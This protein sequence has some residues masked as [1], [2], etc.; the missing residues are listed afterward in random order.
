MIKLLCVIGTRPEAIKMIPIIYAL[1]KI[2]HFN[3]R[4]IAT[5]Q[6]RDMLDQV[7]SLFD[8]HVDIDLNIMKP[9]QTLNSIAGQMLIDLEKVLVA[10]SPDAVIAQG[11][12]TT[13]LAAAM[14]AF[15]RHIPFGHVEA[16]LR[17]HDR[18]HPFPEEMNRVI[19]SNLTEWHFAPSENAKQNLLKEGVAKDKI[20]L[21]G[22]T[23][24]DMVR[25]VTENQLTSS[26]ELDT[27]KRLILVTAHRRENFGAPIREIYKAIRYLADKYDDVQ[28]VYPVHPNPNIEPVAQEMLANHPR[29]KLCKPL[30]YITFINLMKKSYL[31][32]SDSGGIQEEAI[33]LS[34]PVLLLRE[35]TERPEGVDLGGV[36]MV[37]H[38]YESIIKHAQMFLEDTNVYRNAITSASPY[39]DGYAADKIAKVLVEHFVKCRV[40]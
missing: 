28:I 11:D 15:H 13:V 12:T 38:H 35:Q 18:H 25:I 26:I 36:V 8:I 29:I 3:C 7:F 20:F 32:L 5:A 2:P 10:E 33:A 6:H 9:N 1:R 21:T 40:D 31:I 34:K 22:N 27:S 24:V 17:T 19:T 30:D 4:V 16:G 23:V 14:S 39:G 37:G